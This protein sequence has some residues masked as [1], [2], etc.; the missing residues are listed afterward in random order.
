MFF[1][2]FLISRLLQLTL[3]LFLELFKGAW[4]CGYNNINIAKTVKITN[5]FSILI[6][7]HNALIDNFDV[8]F[9]DICSVFLIFYLKTIL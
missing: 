6:R 9:M 5:G 8:R 1:L 3:T 2:C 4:E 7:Q